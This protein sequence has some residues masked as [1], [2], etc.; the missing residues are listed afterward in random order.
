[1]K[2]SELNEQIEKL[3]V[4]INCLQTSYSGAATPFGGGA[5]GGIA[6]QI[7]LP[8]DLS[9]GSPSN[10]LSS[11]TEIYGEEF[12]LLSQNID[13]TLFSQMDRRL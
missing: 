12:A 6:G 8:E 2:V 10:F 5:A 13:P 4:E 3:T 1:M 7:Y 11:G 9:D